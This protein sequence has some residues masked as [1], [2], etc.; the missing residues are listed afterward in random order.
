V[1]TK[2]DERED[3]RGY[4]FEV[5]NHGGEERFAADLISADHP[6]YSS[7]REIGLQFAGELEVLRPQEMGGDFL[8][9]PND[10]TLEIYKLVSEGRIL[11]YSLRYRRPTSGPLLFMANAAGAIDDMLYYRVMLR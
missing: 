8:R 9:L 4:F 10:A 1:L 7:Y 2:L 6:E 3:S 11:G 5:Q